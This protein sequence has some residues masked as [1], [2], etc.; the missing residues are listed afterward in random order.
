MP[1][2]PDADAADRTTNPFEPPGRYGRDS[3]EFGRALAFFDATYS[4][5]A[6][7]L[8]VTLN[9]TD[10][11]WHDWSAFVT[12]EWSSLVCFAISFVVITSYWWINHR[13]VATMDSLNARFVACAMTMLGFVALIPFT[14]EGLSDFADDSKGTVATIVYAA[15]VTVVSVL[16]GLLVVVAYRERLFRHQPSRREL[17]A[18]LLDMADTPFIFLA[19]IPVTVLLGPSWGRTSWALLFF[20]GP[21]SHRLS[22]RYAGRP[23]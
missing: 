21:L 18:R 5:A 6:T 15:N 9:P 7:L 20:T 11:D 14:T 22:D 8:V 17:T 10:A 23:T 1:V 2:A 13:L 3:V 4:I 19:S 12:N 16:A